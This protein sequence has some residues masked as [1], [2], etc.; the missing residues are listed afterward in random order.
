MVWMH[1]TVRRITR[2]QEKE[3][4]SPISPAVDVDQEVK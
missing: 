1:A 4:R 3:M 2:D